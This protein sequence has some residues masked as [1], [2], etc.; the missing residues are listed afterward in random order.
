[1][2]HNLACTQNWLTSEY[3]AMSVSFL[4]EFDLNV[5]MEYKLESAKNKNLGYNYVW[6]VASKKLLFQSY[7][8]YG[9]SCPRTAKV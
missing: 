9:L 7:V 3:G 5:H 8:S 6:V 2:G 1:M 4:S